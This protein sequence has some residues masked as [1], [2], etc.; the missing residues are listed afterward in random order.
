M[1]W[2][3]QSLIQVTSACKVLSGHILRLLLILLPHNSILNTLN[4]LHR[5]KY[6]C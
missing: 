4:D 1:K 2:V 5:F 3:W 6:C